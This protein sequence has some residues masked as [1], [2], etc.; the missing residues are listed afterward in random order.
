MSSLYY[1]LRDLFWTGLAVLLV[2]CFLED[3]SPGFVTLW[4]DMELIA[5]LVGVSGLLAWL[6]GVLSATGLGK[7]N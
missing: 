3:F 7:R 5:V 6:S 1:F 2:F 4:L